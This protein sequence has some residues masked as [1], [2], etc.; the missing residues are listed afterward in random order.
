MFTGRGIKDD[1]NLTDAVKAAMKLRIA[2]GNSA[3]PIIGDPDS[4]VAQMQELSD[5]G[6]SGIAMGLVNY[7]DHFPYF[8]DQVLPRLARAGLRKEVKNG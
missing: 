5:M 8:R 6:L 4:V 7:V 3:Y 1:P 2:A